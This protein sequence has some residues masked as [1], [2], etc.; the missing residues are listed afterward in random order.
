MYRRSETVS[1]VQWGNTVAQSFSNE[2]NWYIS[3]IV[4]ADH[5]SSIHSLFFAI[6]SVGLF[7]NVHDNSG[8]TINDGYNIVSIFYI[9][10][11]GFSQYADRNH[12]SPSTVDVWSAEVVSGTVEHFAID[13]VLIAADRHND[14]AASVWVFI[15]EGVGQGV[16]IDFAIVS[17]Y[18]HNN[19]YSA[20]LVTF[21]IK[22]ASAILHSFVCTKGDLGIGIALICDV[23][24]HGAIYFGEFVISVN[25]R[26]INTVVFAN[27]ALSWVE[28]EGFVA[29]VGNNIQCFFYIHSVDFIIGLNGDDAANYRLV[30]RNVL[31]SIEAEW[32]VLSNRVGS[33]SCAIDTNTEIGSRSKNLQTLSVNEINFTGYLLT[34]GNLIIYSSDS[35]IISIA[36]ST[37]INSS[38]ANVEAFSFAKFSEGEGSS[39]VLTIVQRYGYSVFTSN[40]ILNRAV[41]NIFDGVNRT[42]PS[43]LDIIF[44]QI[45]AFWN[46]YI[47]KVSMICSGSIS[48]WQQCEHFFTSSITVISVLD[49]EL[50][51]F[52]HGGVLVV[53]ILIVSTSKHYA[54]I[55]NGFNINRSHSLLSNGDISVCIVFCFSN[56]DVKYT[57][58]SQTESK[59]E[60]ALCIGGNLGAIKS[61]TSI[62]A[63]DLQNFVFSSITISVPSVTFNSV[64]LQAIRGYLVINGV[65]PESFMILISL[66]LR[67]CYLIS[68]T[69]ILDV[70]LISGG[71]LSSHVYSDRTNFIVAGDLCWICSYSS[72]DF[73]AIAIVVESSS[74]SMTIVNITGYFPN[75]STIHASCT[76]ES[77]VVDNSVLAIFNPDVNLGV[78]SSVQSIV[79]IAVNIEFK[80]KSFAFGSRNRTFSSFLVSYSKETA[81]INI[82]NLSGIIN[83]DRTYRNPV[84]RS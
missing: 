62:L 44:G 5:C 43:K 55:F 11:E 14:V 56:N 29:I 3:T 67:H 75:I 27:R 42:I 68:A 10:A 38:H 59:F 60:V 2:T 53:D 50:Y 83:C 28:T 1:I 36:A 71:S 26:Y 77:S 51:C 47:D 41:A 69:G 33:N 80:R 48:S 35:I 31:Y 21:E 13:Q 17:L 32:I 65:V 49:V 9:C 37:L 23:G 70:D 63:R 7:A 72:V 20:S 24:S 30:S 16:G 66:S 18:S 74:Q 84:T 81:A 39:S 52:A 64:V 82:N 6:Y 25:N 15:A 61:Q 54:A 19:I 40:E 22:L 76:R 34:K 79:A 73:I 46:S 57:C 8:V 78:R 45:R 4:I 58:I 12:R